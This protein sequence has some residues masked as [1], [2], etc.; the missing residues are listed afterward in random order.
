MKAA[1]FDAW[2]SALEKPEIWRQGRGEFE[3]PDGC[4]CA[5]GVL[6]RVD[7]WTKGLKRRVDSM[8]RV[9]YLYDGYMMSGYPCFSY[10]EINNL[11]EEF[12]DE[13]INM[14]DNP[15]GPTF[16]EIAKKL[17]EERNKYVD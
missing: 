4:F 5:I 16:P 11:N 1:L 14:N 6:L 15:S 12:L 2:V 7:R 17:K 3:S 8:G 10:R 13:L 9:D